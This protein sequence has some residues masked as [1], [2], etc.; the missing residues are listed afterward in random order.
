MAGYYGAESKESWKFWYPPDPPWRKGYNS[1][2]A[3]RQYR[4]GGGKKS[5]NY[6]MCSCGNWKWGTRWATHCDSCGK[7]WPEP[8]SSSSEEERSEGKQEAAATNG[9]GAEPLDAAARAQVQSMVEGLGALLGMPLHGVLAAYL[10][11]EPAGSRRDQRTEGQ[12]WEQVRVARSKAANNATAAKKAGRKADQLERQYDEAKLVAAAANLAQK[13]AEEE[14][15]E[16]RKEYFQK[17]IRGERNMEE[18]MADEEAAIGPHCDLDGEDIDLGGE[19]QEELQQE[20]RDLKEMQ[21]KMAKDRDTFIQKR[22]DLEG[23]IEAA[24]KAKVAKEDKEGNVKEAAPISQGSAGSS[25]ERQ[26]GRRSR[27]TSPRRIP[28]VPAKCDS[29]GRRGRPSL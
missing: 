1:K 3:D 10:P 4:R 23:R 21:A 2:K 16:M 26:E 11:A 7:R 28:K 14:L 13:E 12:H 6:V 25:S 15:A 29:E 19:Q 27:S 20:E 9:A 18:Y 5:Q 8:G 22:R 17:E 24:K